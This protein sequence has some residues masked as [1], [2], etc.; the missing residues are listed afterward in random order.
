MQIN[1]FA[2]DPRRPTIEHLIL[3]YRQAK[4]ALW[5][6]RSMTGK[7]R[8][9]AFERDLPNRLAS[10]RDRLRD[11][12]E[13]FDTVEVGD[14]FVVPKRVKRDALVNPSFTVIGGDDDHGPHT[15]DVRVQLCPDPEFAIVEVLYLWAYGPLLDALL[16]SEAVGSRLDLASAQRPVDPTRRSLFQYW[17]DRYREFRSVPLRDARH[18]MATKPTQACL[19]VSTDLVAFYDNIDA[20]FLR[21]P[22]FMR[23]LQS[24]AALR[25]EN[26]RPQAYQAVT[27]SL[28]RAYGRFNAQTTHTTGIPRSRGIPIGSITSRVV[29]NVALRRLD[30]H[31]LGVEGVISYRRYVD[32]MLIVAKARDEADDGA[33]LKRLLPVLPATTSTNAIH[34]NSRYLRRPGSVFALQLEKVRIYKLEGP[35]GIEFLKAVGSDI[36]RL[37][38]ERRA[39]ADEAILSGTRDLPLVTA[40][41]RA[42]SRLRVLRDAD[43]T[44]LQHYAFVSAMKTLERAARLL[45]ARNALLT[46]RKRLRPAL[47]VLQDDDVWVDN[48]EALLRVISLAA[49]VGDAETLLKLVKRTDEQWDKLLSFSVKGLSGIQWNGEPLTR[50]RARQRLREY[51]HQRRLEAICSAL[52][53]TVTTAKGLLPGLQYGSKR[54]SPRALR[55]KSR[56]MV[57]ADLRLL[58]REQECARGTPVMYF[59]NDDIGAR[60]SSNSALAQRLH[61]IDTFI[62][63]ARGRP[64]SPWSTSAL[65][66]FLSSRPPRYMDVAEIMLSKLPAEGPTNA[67]FDRVRVVVNAIRGTNY[68]EPAAAVVAPWTVAIGPTPSPASLW[69]PPVRL[70]LGNL[71]LN[72]SWCLAA[73]SA[74]TTQQKVERLGLHGP[75]RLVGLTQVLHRATEI[76]RM[77]VQGPDGQM[78]VPNSLLVLPELALPRQW[79]REL[80]ERVVGEL[81]FDVVTGLEYSHHRSGIGVFNQVVGVFRLPFRSGMA[82]LWTKRRPAR[83]EQAELEGV[84]QHFY[85]LPHTDGH[86]V[87]RSIHGDLSVLVCSEIIESKMVASLLGRVETVLVPSWNKD[88]ASYDHLIQSVGLQLNAFVAVAN[89]GKY[90]DCRVW[91]PRSERWQRDQC[92]LI[93]RKENDA[94]FVDLPLESLRDFRQRGADPKATD[95]KSEEWKPLP[96]EWP[97]ATGSP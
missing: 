57:R 95:A 52:P 76:A 59:G 89:N 39:F 26:F 32:D 56:L 55:A 22:E 6:D 21:Q 10:L 67:L 27:E 5:L 3:A 13:W 49:L 92:R 62:E 88:T 30:Q 8:A 64:R 70:I 58:D 35:A 68:S 9:A 65:S 83:E 85:P 33:V 91:A 60:L 93:S 37:S 94:V 42:S 2:I 1:S 71:V 74:R 23:S 19:V 90:S 7:L 66:L 53:V 73:A 96:P 34:L 45:D 24:V 14:A 15:L 78:K 29:A 17:P 84:G 40:T 50:L 69:Q 12:D 18:E 75:R 20:N 77:P 25:G 31:V 11:S 44:R 41:A 87:V 4:A 81:P 48:L 38:S 61:T 28:L 80:A 16:P 86:L 63:Q 43:R 79:F 82:C 47:R 54:L 97:S 72:E 36:A 46:V 51:L